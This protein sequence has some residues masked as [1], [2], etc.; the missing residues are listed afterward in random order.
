MGVDGGA[1]G[2]RRHPNSENENT[3]AKNEPEINSFYGFDGAR[4]FRPRRAPYHFKLGKNLVED[5][6]ANSIYHL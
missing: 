1:L 4:L 6:S 3:N 5:C 2:W